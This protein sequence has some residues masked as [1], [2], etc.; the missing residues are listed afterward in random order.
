D[1]VDRSQDGDRSRESRDPGD[2][3]TI[4]VVGS[5]QRP[6][7]ECVR[8]DGDRHGCGEPSRLLEVARNRCSREQHE[9]KDHRAECDRYVEAMDRTVRALHTSPIAATL[10][11]FVLLLAPALW[12]RYPLLQP[13]AAISPAGTKATWCRAARRCSGCFS[14]SAKAFISGPS[15]F[16]KPP[17]P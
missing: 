10:C 17:A 2:A 15:S 5:R 16:C 11:C 13:P 4:A 7:G 3:R 14:T 12:N 6:A 8:K 9:R 1:G